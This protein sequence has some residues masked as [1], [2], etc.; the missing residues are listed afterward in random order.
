MAA[1]HHIIGEKAAAAKT[2]RVAKQNALARKRA[3]IAHRIFA[4]TARS[5]RGIIAR[6]AQ[7]RHSIK[8]AIARNSW[9]NRAYRAGGIARRR[10]G[11]IGIEINARVNSRYH[12]VSRRRRSRACNATYNNA[13]AN[14][15]SRG[16]RV[17][18]KTNMPGAYARQTLSRATC[19]ASLASRA[20]R[21]IG[22]HISSS[23]IKHQQI[24]IIIK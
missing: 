24:G 22:A 3:H 18:Y 16:R 7:H 19:A 21:G 6:I 1:R 2:R 13:R 23:I 5:S 4:K 15:R 9:R 20:L 17:A 11:D 10:G 12:R 8:R 14:V